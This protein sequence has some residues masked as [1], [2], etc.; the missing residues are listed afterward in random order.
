MPLNRGLDSFITGGFAG[1]LLFEALFAGLEEDIPNEYQE[2]KLRSRFDFHDVEI[3]DTEEPVSLDDDSFRFYIGQSNKKTSANKVLI[4]EWDAY[5]QL[6]NREGIVP[7]LFEG[8]RLI[9]KRVQIEYGKDKE[10]K[11]MNPS[12]IWVPVGKPGDDVEKLKKTTVTRQ[13]GG[14]A[15][16]LNALIVE[17]STM[18][19]TQEGVKKLIASENAET[20]KLVSK[21]GGL[22]KVLKALVEAKRIQLD[23][24][25]YTT[26]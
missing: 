13:S 4:K 14:D 24:G 21:G 20:R 7:D 8:D 11:E 2:N 12:N 9:F 17:A 26:V 5:A 6:T 23:D 16:V 22:V 19:V 10:G 25:V 1:I 15:E 3:L 18:G